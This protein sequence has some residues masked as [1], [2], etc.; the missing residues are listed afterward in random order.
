MGTGLAPVPPNVAECR[1]TARRRSRHPAAAVGACALALVLA[2]ALGGCGDPQRRDPTGTVPQ[3]TAPVPSGPHLYCIANVGQTLVAYDLVTRRPLPATARRLALD[4]VGPWFAGGAGYYLSRV[5]TSGAGAN[6]LIRFDPRTTAELGR[7]VF[8][9]NHAPSNPNSLLVLPPP[10]PPVAWVALRGSTFD[11]FASDGI[12]V[13][14]LGALADTAFCDLN[15]DTPTCAWPARTRTG[16]TSPLGFVWDAAC[17]AAGCAYALVNNFDG[18]V[19]DGAL[20]VLEPDAQG[21]PVLRD[22][23][24]LGRNPLLPMALAGT[25]LWVV[26]NGGYVHFGSEG[27]AGTLQVLDTTAFD[28]GMPGNETLDVQ[29]VAPAGTDCSALPRPDPGCD[30]TGIHAEGGTAWVTTYP[31]DVLRTVELGTRTLLPLGPAPYAP[32]I[33]GPFFPVTSPAPALFAALGGLGTARLGEVDPAG[34][35][36]LS[37]QSLQAGPGPLSCAEYTVP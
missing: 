24:P 37:D 32:R 36:L 7:L 34:P 33:T 18:A 20:L 27:Q 21:V 8:F 2:L 14:D 30:P 22:T 6:A 15:A 11:G 13:V 35:T 4:P 16:L 9:S 29:T 1:H 17:G 12:S 10:H 25:E 5:D 31:D 19:R 3:S 28:D 23:I 26:N